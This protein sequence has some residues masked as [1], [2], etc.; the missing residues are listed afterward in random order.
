MKTFFDSVGFT[1]KGNDQYFQVKKNHK[2]LPESVFSIEN[3]LSFL[4]LQ[5]VNSFWLS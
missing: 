4:S 2:R 3:T 1:F 5:A